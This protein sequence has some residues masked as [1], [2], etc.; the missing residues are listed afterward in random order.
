MQ[1][2][3]S[4]NLP[5]EVERLNQ[6]GIQLY[7]KYQF[8]EALEKFQKVLALVRELKD[9]V[10]ERATLN[11]IAAVY[12]SQGQ[13]PKAIE[14]YEQILVLVRELEDKPGEGTT[15]NNLATVYSNQGQYPSD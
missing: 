7:Q 13:Y 4:Q 15:L 10:G 1:A 8:P 3:T 5:T 14:T 9:K 2:Q 6:E 11:S 12:E